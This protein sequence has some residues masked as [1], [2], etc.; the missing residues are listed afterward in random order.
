MVDIF[1]AGACISCQRD[2]IRTVRESRTARIEAISEQPLKSVKYMIANMAKEFRACLGSV[3]PAGEGNVRI[4]RAGAQLL[5][6]EIGQTIC[7]SPL[8]PAA[9]TEVKA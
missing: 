5:G 8:R 9:A 3:E 7:Y 6:V 1:D 4:E 2:Q